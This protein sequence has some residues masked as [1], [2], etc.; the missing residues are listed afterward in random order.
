MQVKPIPSNTLTATVTL[1][2]PYVAELTPTSLVK[3]LKQADSTA[4]DLPRMID[5]HEAAKCLGLSW[6]SVVRMIKTGKIDGVKVGQ[7]WRIPVDE[8][9]RFAAGEG[10]K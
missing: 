1:L 10:G 3:A 2:G 5:K 6:H 8:L 4:P 7:Q 9:R